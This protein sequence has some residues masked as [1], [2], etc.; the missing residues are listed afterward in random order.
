MNEY[1]QIQSELRK[2]GK[3]I[4]SLQATISELREEVKTEREA[5]CKDVCAWCEKVGMLNSEQKI[6]PAA[7]TANEQYEHVL[8]WDEDGKETKTRCNASHIR[9]RTW[10]EDKKNTS[11]LKGGE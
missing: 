5:C 3:A 8:I 2:R 10:R 6:M 9:I 1:D 7:L 4:E 11:A